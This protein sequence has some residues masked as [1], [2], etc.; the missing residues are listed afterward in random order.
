MTSVGNPT[1]FSFADHNLT[2]DKTLHSQRNSF[3]LCHNS[4]PRVLSGGGLIYYFL[5]SASSFAQNADRAGGGTSKMYPEDLKFLRLTYCSCGITARRVPPPWKYS[6]KTDRCASQL[7]SDY[8]PEE[9]WLIVSELVAVAN[10]VGF[11]TSQPSLFKRQQL[12]PVRDLKLLV[13]DYSV[14]LNLCTWWIFNILL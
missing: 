13:R 10:L 6:D 12:L 1:K 11:S 2:R 9:H 8:K 5:G 14:S 4:R 7:H 3:L